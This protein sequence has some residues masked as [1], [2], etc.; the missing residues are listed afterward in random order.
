MGPMSNLM[1]AINAM[2]LSKIKYAPIKMRLERLA[3]SLSNSIKNNRFMAVGFLLD[4]KTAL[5]DFFAF[6][7]NA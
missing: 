3:R 5:Q 4:V 1:A 7:Q 2:E 6:G